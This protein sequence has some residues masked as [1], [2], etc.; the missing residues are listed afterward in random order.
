FTR[1]GPAAG[2][3]QTWGPLA[4]DFHQPDAFPLMIVGS[5]KAYFEHR[6]EETRQAYTLLPMN[7]PELHQKAE[8]AMAALAKTIASNGD[9][10]DWFL[11]ID[12][13]FRNLGNLFT[14][15]SLEG[16]SF[17][18]WEPDDPWGNN[19]T[20]SML[21]KPVQKI[22]ITM[23]R[24]SEARRGIVFS[25]MTDRPF[26]GQI[27]CFEKWPMQGGAKAFNNEPWNAFLSGIQFAEGL[28]IMDNAKNLF[29]DPLS[30]LPMNTVVRA[31]AN[32]TVPLWLTVS[33]KGLEPGTYTGT[34][35]AKGDYPGFGIQL[36]E[37]EVK[38]ID[39]NPDDFACV[40]M[41]FTYMLRNNCHPNHAR[42]LSDR[43]LNTIFSGML[44][45]PEMNE[46][47]SIGEAD[48]SR[49][50]Q[51]LATCFANGFDPKTCHVIVYL[52]MEKKWAMVHNGK[53]RHPYGTPLFTKAFKLFLKD[54]AAHLDKTFGVSTRQL[55]IYPCDEPGGDWNDPKS[56]M[57]IAW[58]AGNWI[59][60]AIP[61]ARRFIDPH[62]F[63][64]KR[65]KLTDETMDKIFGIFD[66]VMLYR[67]SNTLPDVIEAAKRHNCTIWTYG[68]LDKAVH[69]SI[70]RRFF[71]QNLRDGIGSTAAFW[72]VDSHAGGDGFDSFD[73]S[74]Y[75]PK[76]RSDY[77]TL[78]PD[79]NYGT[80]LSSRRFDAWCDG[81]ADYRIA[82]LCLKAI[83]GRPDRETMEKQLQDIFT[84]GAS[85]TIPDMEAA[86]IKLLKFYEENC[87]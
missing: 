79:W 1:S 54:F 67:P 44:P 77:G 16:R 30:P 45:Y 28:P 62:P 81:F 13:A 51:T 60:E 61:E 39:V 24:N 75:D 56:T 18:L 36:I 69:P 63:G 32:G 8:D 40:N 20:V 49:F 84:E 72:H 46:D 52:A 12:R 26:L 70:F 31:S 66:I 22:A 50:D 85:G 10:R 80:V 11:R 87:K 43:G 2:G 73:C 25:N 74:G 37:L 76:N 19:L 58:N 83:A 5:R 35:V 86:R 57:N 59:K 48:Y 29:Y 38:V 78:Y 4:T 55:I 14:S 33:S 47:G 23:P 71:W 53:V 21:S 17:V 9:S 41:N 34:I 6:L 64:T 15:I 82:H 68:I 27:K 7:A 65:K 3:L 42:F